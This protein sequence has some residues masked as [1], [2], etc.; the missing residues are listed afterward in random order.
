MVFSSLVFL[1]IFLPITF[2]LHY[3]I[4][5]IRIRNILLII[6]SLIF[7]AYGEPVYVLLMIASSFL[8]YLFALLMG[9]G[10]K[11]PLLILAVVVNIGVLCGFI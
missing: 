10:F 6:A 2:C 4:P 1:C 5:S 3:V 7:Y 8:N 9:R 11:K